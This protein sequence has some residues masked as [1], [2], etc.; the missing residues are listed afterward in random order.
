MSYLSFY[1]AV[2]SETQF[3]MR[4]NENTQARPQLKRVKQCLDEIRSQQGFSLNNCTYQV[5]ERE[6]ETPL[7][8][9]ECLGWFRNLFFCSTNLHPCSWFFSVSPWVSLVLFYHLSVRIVWFLVTITLSLFLAVCLHLIQLLIVSLLWVW[10]HTDLI[11]LQGSS[12]DSG[13]S[14]W[15]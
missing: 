8:W 2:M 15:N 5:I 7:Q 11:C 10:S 12:Q 6:A 4:K 9:R 14:Q 13:R 3:S 1:V